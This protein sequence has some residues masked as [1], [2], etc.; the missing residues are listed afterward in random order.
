M[1]MDSKSGLSFEFLKGRQHFLEIKEDWNVL[2]NDNPQR[3]DIFL[4]H[5][6]NLIWADTFCSEKNNDSELVLLTGRE[7][8][9]LVMILPLL[10]R[11]KFGI[12]QLRWMGDPVSQYGAALLQHDL[13]LVVVMQDVMTFIP[14]HYNLDLLVLP[15]IGE[16]SPLSVALQ[17]IDV[18]QYGKHQA[19]MIDLSSYNN[20][21]DYWRSRSKSS[22]KQ[23]RRLRRKLALEHGELS[24]RM[25]KGCDEDAVK[26]MKIALQL[27]HKN[28]QNS[29]IYSAA[30]ATGKMEQFFLNIAKNDYEGLLISEMKCGNTIIALEVGF[31][32]NGYYVS[33]IGVYD[34]AYYAY[35][36]GKIQM[37]YTIDG[38]MEMGITVVDLLPP[39]DLYKYIMANETEVVLDFGVPFSMKGRFYMR[40]ILQKLRPFAKE[41]KTSIS[42]N[43]LPANMKKWLGTLSSHSK[44][45]N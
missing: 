20:S 30:F 19:P 38:L 10:Y 31:E 24:F 5:E 29:N 9:K 18:R 11:V 36:P 33:H 25:V 35:S 28:L 43:K 42:T 26:L 2:L 34:P 32:R 7:Q 3:H 15:A 27:K 44:S 1:K 8:G 4:T 14:Q 16:N 17:N 39:P 45:R 13:D 40:A 37:A 23:R 41:V 6:W 21:D 12:K 22:N